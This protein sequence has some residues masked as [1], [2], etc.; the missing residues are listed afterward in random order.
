MKYCVCTDALY[1]KQADTI[2]AITELH[3]LGIDAYEFWF[4]WQQDLARLK[5]QQDKLGMTCCAICAKFLKNPGDPTEQ[6]N[7]LA[8]FRESVVA[9]KTLDCK[10]LIVQAGWEKPNLPW[11]LHRTTLLDTLVQAGEIADSED[12]TL[13]LEPLNIKVDHPG[14]HLWDTDDAFQVVQE[15]N[16]PN[17]KLLFDIYHQQI[18]CGNIAASLSAH[19]DQIG[20][21]HCAGVPGRHEITDGELNYAYIFSLLKQL[22]YPEYVGL[23]YFT[24]APVLESIRQAKNLFVY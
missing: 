2:S 6:S 20:H 5:E 1:M 7:Y 15:V 4:W 23:E 8:D 22:N 18:S 10:K 24:D 3:S 17:V 14:Y 13:V 11:K 19:L 16:R 21:I 9:A 12:I